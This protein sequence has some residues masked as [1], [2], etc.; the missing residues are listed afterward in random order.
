MES[1]WPLGKIRVI[2]IHH[3]DFRLLLVDS[4]R[5]I[6]FKSRLGTERN[7][8]T[9]FISLYIDF[10]VFLSLFLLYEISSRKFSL[11]RRIFNILSRVEARRSFPLDTVN[12]I[13]RFRVSISCQCVDRRNFKFS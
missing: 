13:D 2:I 12:L 8:V 6:L 11:L 9:I 4:S 1:R 3:S 5:K 10:T 7:D